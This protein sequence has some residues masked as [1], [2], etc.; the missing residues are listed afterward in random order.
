MAHPPNPSFSLLLWLKAVSLSSLL[1]RSVSG[2]ILPMG[3]YYEEKAHSS[4]L[5]RKAYAQSFGPLLCFVPLRSVSCIHV[6]LN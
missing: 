6:F 3:H 5:R 4:L 2:P 1:P